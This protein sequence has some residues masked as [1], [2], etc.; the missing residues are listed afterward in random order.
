MLLLGRV[1]CLQVATPPPAQAYQR[2][3]I[4]HLLPEAGINVARAGRAGAATTMAAIPP[5]K[6]TPE[7]QDVIASVST[8]VVL[9]MPANAP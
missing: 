9:A 7:G 3:S 4:M 8:E 2:P 5:A 6:A 1:A